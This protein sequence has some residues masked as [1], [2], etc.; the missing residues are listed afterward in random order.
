MGTVCR[1]ITPGPGLR[2]QQ[3]G[4]AGVRGP[5][6]CLELSERNQRSGRSELL[7]WLA[8]PSPGLWHFGG[9]N[10]QGS[11]AQ[12]VG[13]AQPLHSCETISFV[14]NWPRW[15]YL[16][17]AQPRHP[18]TNSPVP[19][20][21]H[22]AWN[23]NKNQEKGERSGPGLEQNCSPR[24]LLHHGWHDCPCHRAGS[25]SLVTRTSVGGGCAV[26]GVRRLLCSQCLISSTPMGDA[27]WAT[28]VL[29]HFGLS[30]I[31]MDGISWHRS[32][33]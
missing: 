30:H 10:W 12:G 5:G 6:G 8:S 29:G 21:Q 13:A 15:G 27:T 14:I 17:P 18:V 23:T 28:A 31:I 22:S 24:A 26:G 7:A 19:V 2:E 3:L 16:P 9:L 20:Q 33:L 11:A 25:V 1:C 32:E 4:S